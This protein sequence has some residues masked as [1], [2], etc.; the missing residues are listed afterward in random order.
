[1]NVIDHIYIGIL[2]RT[3][4]ITINR[5]FSTFVQHQ[6]RAHENA[7]PRSRTTP[8]IMSVMWDQATGQPEFL[9]ALN[10]LNPHNNM[11][12]YSLLS[13]AWIRIKLALLQRAQNVQT[14]VEALVYNRSRSGKR[15][16]LARPTRPPLPETCGPLSSRLFSMST[17]SAHPPRNHMLTRH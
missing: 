11:T 2:P 17:S 10:S 15:A 9:I 16:H 1:M 14:I 12:L 4:H 5:F 13:K 7:F 3:A 6:Q 8:H